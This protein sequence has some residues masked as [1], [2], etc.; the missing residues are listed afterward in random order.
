[1][2]ES[3]DFDDFWIGRGQKLVEDTFTNLN[4]RLSNYIAYLKYLKGFFIIS[5]LTTLGFYQTTDP[6]V[7]GSFII[8]VIFLYLAT[9]QISVASEVQIEQLDLRSPLKINEAFHDLVIGLKEEVEN[10]RSTV[11]WTTIVVLIGGT[12]AIYNLNKQNESG[13]TK[14][15]QKTFLNE[16]KKD[17]K[18]SFTLNDKINKLTVEGKLVK[19][20]TYNITYARDSKND[21]TILINIPALIDFKRDI[22][23]IKSLIEVKEG[24]TK[25]KTTS[26]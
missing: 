7:F 16:A 10:A 4:K 19:E 1:M 14:K 21:T 2:A 24:T 25:I 20:K 13:Q 11:A 5:G 23:N 3:K 22:D 15:E 26:N 12:I 9:F 17:Q 18:L 8:P 6:W